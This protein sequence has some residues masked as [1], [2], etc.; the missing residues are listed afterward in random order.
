MSQLNFSRF[1]SKDWGFPLNIIWL[2][3][4]IIS[5]LVDMNKDYINILILDLDRLT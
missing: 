2:I 1:L 3:G 5:H 4:F